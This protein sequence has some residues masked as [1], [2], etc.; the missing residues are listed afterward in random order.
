MTKKLEHMP[1]STAA[2]AVE[3]SKPSLEL[4]RAIGEQEVRL[5]ATNG[6]PKSDAA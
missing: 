1:D 6:A 3:W 2:E 5:Q 4:E